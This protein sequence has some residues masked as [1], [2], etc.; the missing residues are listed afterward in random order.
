MIAYDNPSKSE[1][2]IVE[3]VLDVIQG[4]TNETAAGASYTQVV[5]PIVEEHLTKA[6]EDGSIKPNEKPLAMAGSL[7]LLNGIDLLFATNPDWGDNYTDS[8]VIVDA[9]LQGAS[10]G[11][12][13]GDD[14]PRIISARQSHATRARAF[15]GTFRGI[16]ESK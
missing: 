12:Q 10:T 7:A 2:A 14:D 11:L 5:F 4:V 1:V 8:V 3:G 6:V 15:K 9:F 16:N 13:L